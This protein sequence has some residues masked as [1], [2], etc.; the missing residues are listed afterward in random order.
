MIQI[1]EYNLGSIE[2]ELDED[3]KDI[4]NQ[5][6]SDLKKISRIKTIESFFKDLEPI[7]NIED[8]SSFIKAPR[9]KIEQLKQI[10]TS[11]IINDL[12]SFNTKFKSLALHLKKKKKYK[13]CTLNDILEFIFGYHLES[14]TQ[15]LKKVLRTIDLQNCVY[16]LAQY[17]TSYGLDKKKIYVKGNLDHIYP[18][19][20]N[21]LV[22]LS[23]NNLVP[24][25]GHCNQRKS[26]APLADFNFN[27]FD[28][29][30]IPIFKF[31]DVLEI[32]IGQVNFKNLT[33]LKIE[34]VN[35][36]LES[37]LE[38]TSLYKE[39]KSPIENLLERYKKFNSSSYEAHIQKLL[40]R[41]ISAD[42]E[43]FISETPYTEENLQNI[44]LHKF[45]SDFYKELEG[46][47][48][49]GKIKF[50]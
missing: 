30:I 14:R 35:S 37:R 19:S 10:D 28:S 46:Y 15:T 39:Y 7:I 43:Y 50:S 40:G 22:S 20:L 27:P 34:N 49:S 41:G 48:K 12:R 6:K 2:S 4:D 47:K 32:N 3:I 36:T 42:L 33:D 5:I 16:C 45:K 11:I 23:I 1:K 31:E 17:T 9:N 24:V 13:K 38:L 29:S 44:P 21:A 25:C 8:D 26:D 18:K